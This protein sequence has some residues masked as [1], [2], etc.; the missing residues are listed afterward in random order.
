MAGWVCVIAQIK[1]INLSME[2]LVK[3]GVIDIYWILSWLPIDV[4]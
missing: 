1:C 2:C 3:L 4:T